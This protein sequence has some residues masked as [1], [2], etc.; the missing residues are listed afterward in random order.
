M[1]CLLAR[2]LAVVCVRVRACVCVCVCVCV[3]ADLAV[4][5]VSGAPRE[6][7]KPLPLGSSA[8]G[9]LRVGQMCL[10][11][12]NRERAVGR[13]QLSPLRTPTAHAHMHAC[14]TS[15]Q[16]RVQA[17]VDALLFAACLLPRSLWV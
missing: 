4:L 9:L 11:I 5:Q 2:A 3:C 15:T 16:L 12:G 17:C 7:F 10:A 8:R 13:G 6:Y 1:V 14:A